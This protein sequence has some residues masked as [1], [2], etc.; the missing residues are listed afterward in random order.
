MSVDFD[1][2]VLA[3]VLGI[4]GDPCQYVPAQR[5]NPVPITGVFEEF[6]RT[7]NVS[8]DG[9]AVEDSRAVLG[10][11]LADFPTT[12]GPALEELV[13]TSDGRWWS[14]DNI[15]PD[16]VGHLKLILKLAPNGLPP[17]V[18]PPVILPPGPLGSSSGS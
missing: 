9:A 8:G 12:D 3:P 2:L 15:E 4:F 1:T 13:Q 5:A 10:V 11:R 6:H 17:Y 16:G 7:I 14:I 18:T